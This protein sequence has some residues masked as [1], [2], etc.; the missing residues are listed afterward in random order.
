MF[1]HWY[2]LLKYFISFE[3]FVQYFPLVVV[4]NLLIMAVINNAAL[5]S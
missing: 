3:L 5:L 4:S 1:L 2:V